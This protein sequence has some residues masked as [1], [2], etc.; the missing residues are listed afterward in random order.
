M[1]GG[2]EKES[3]LKALAS[4][5]LDVIIRDPSSG[6]TVEV[7]SGCLSFNP[8]GILLVSKSF[9]SI[10]QSV[11]KEVCVQFY[12][13]QV[14]YCFNS[15]VQDS[16]MGLALVIPKTIERV[17]SSS[18][19]EVQSFKANLLYHDENQKPVVIPCNVPESYN[20]LTK[21]ALTSIPPEFQPECKK[22]M[23]GFI[24]ER[25]GGNPGI[26][27]SGLHL[28]SV[29][30]YLCDPNVKSNLN[31]IHGTQ[32]PLDLI[33]L[34]GD[35]LMLGKRQYSQKLELESDYTLNLEVILSAFLTRSISI[36]FT[37]VDLYDTPSSAP[38]CYHC[39]ITDIKTEDRRFISERMK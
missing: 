11:G 27:G 34:D 7:P 9:G 14:G 6:I 36:G 16:S 20:L 29:S 22:L 10:D 33:Y 5:T 39:K 19:I 25:K 15:V 1:V 31:S 13:N 21:P 37:V 17:R 26:I 2:L 18:G 3:V 12:V 24:N 30:F 8:Q 28:I 4:G 32:E 35:K 38:L 23:A